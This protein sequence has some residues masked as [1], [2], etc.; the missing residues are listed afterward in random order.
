MTET[1]L[2]LLPRT[3]QTGMRAT[4][5]KPDTDCQATRQ[6]SLTPR[7]CA[8]CKEKLQRI[9]GSMPQSCNL[10]SSG[11]Y[12]ASRPKK[13]RIGEMQCRTNAEQHDDL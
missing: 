11:P 4:G 2:Q 1:P 6:G 7:V 13:D 5:E 12:K 10:R 9:P 8:A 3:S